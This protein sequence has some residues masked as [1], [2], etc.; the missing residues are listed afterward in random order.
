MEVTD[1][2]EDAEPMQQQQQQQSERPARPAAGGAVSMSDLLQKY[3]W[4][5]PE[6]E[7]LLDEVRPQHACDA[8]FASFFV[9]VV[10]GASRR[11]PR[12]STTA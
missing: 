12:P 7:R 2:V 6:L 3:E 1:D 8:R 5:T 10:P 4:G 9:V 11:R